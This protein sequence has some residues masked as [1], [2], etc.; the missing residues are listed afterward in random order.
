[1]YK[2]NKIKQCSAV[3]PFVRYKNPTFRAPRTHKETASFALSSTCDFADRSS[4]NAVSCNALHVKAGYVN[5]HYMQTLHTLTLDPCT[6]WVNADF[7][8]VN[9]LQNGD[10][11]I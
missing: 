11:I 4:V 6:I 5:R 2:K 3:L 9:Q 1:M 8:T 10:S 7:K